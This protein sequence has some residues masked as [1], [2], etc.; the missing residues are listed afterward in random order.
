MNFNK[1]RFNKQ[2][3]S[4]FSDLVVT[5]TRNPGSWNIDIIINS[6]TDENMFKPGFYFFVDKNTGEGLNVYTVGRQRVNEKFRTNYGLYTIINKIQAAKFKPAAKLK[7]HL[8]AKTEIEVYYV[9]MEN[10]KYLTNKVGK[11]GT[12]F[13]K[14]AK[15]ET[16]IYNN[17]HE[18]KSRIK[19]NYSFKY[20]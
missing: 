13:G 18:V 19:D 16:D 15:T 9:S 4:G 12:L 14:L 8:S 11:Q 5:L 1:V 3:V 20:N 7:R 10:A 17:M 6:Q 2:H